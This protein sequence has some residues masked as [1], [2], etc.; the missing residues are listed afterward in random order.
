VAA[1]KN[2]KRETLAVVAFGGNFLIPKGD[3]GYQADQLRYART[4]VK[5]LMRLVEK[6]FKLVVVHGNGPQVGMEMILVEEAA[7]QVPTVTLDVCVAKTQGAIAYL[8]E[9]AFREELAK[10]KLDIPVASLVT[11]VEIDAQDSAMK[12]PTK[13]VGYFFNSVQAKRLI[14]EKRWTMVEDAGRGWRKVVPSPKPIGIPCI[15]SIKALV[16]TGAIVIAGGGGGIPITVKNDQYV[17]IEAVIDKD[18]TA[19][20]LGNLLG[21]DILINLTPVECVAVNFGTSQ[22]RKLYT[23]SVQEALKHLADGHFAAGS[24]APKIAA[25]CEFLQKG[26]EQ[27]LITSGKSL[28]AALRGRTGTRIVSGLPQQN[29]FD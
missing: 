25:T 28:V 18:Y 14:K 22:E 24:M 16:K 20:L 13:P 15:E 7:N 3:P 21:A 4:A 8:L 1:K 29:L 6:G 17:G 19:A 26:G 5:T 2:E 10:K 11:S 12:K 23:I 9:H 27:S